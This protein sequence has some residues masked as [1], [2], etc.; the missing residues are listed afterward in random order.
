MI[1]STT[2][3][4]LC[5]QAPSLPTPAADTERENTIKKK[6]SRC[7]L[8]TDRENDDRQLFQDLLK[9]LN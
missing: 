9:E 1:G 2:A 4:L 7:Q 3:V 6:L 8:T 5:R